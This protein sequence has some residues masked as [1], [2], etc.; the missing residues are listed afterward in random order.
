MI[1][2][3][4]ILIIKC[5]WLIIPRSSRRK[6]L[7]KV[8]C[9]HYVYQQ[10]KINGHAGLRALLFRIKNCNPSYQIIDLGDEKILVTKTNKVFSEK[11]LNK[12]ILNP[13]NA[14]EKTKAPKQ[15]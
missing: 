4:L 5:Y 10:T 12:L 13:P 3:I 2:A 14:P 8:S 6:C 11:E 9:S 7:F 1:K 15:C